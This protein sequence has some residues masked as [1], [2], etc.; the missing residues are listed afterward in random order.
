MGTRLVTVRLAPYVQGYWLIGASGVIA[1]DAGPKG[2][3]QR[4]LA[5]LQAAGGSSAQVRLILVTH[6]HL[7]HF[8]GAEALRA[9][10]GAPVAVHALDAEALHRGQNDPAALRPR[11]WVARV[12]QVLPF[13][14]GGAPLAGFK[15]DLVIAEARDFDL[16]AYGIPGRLISTPGHTPGSVSLLLEDG[17]ALIGDLLMGQLWAPQSPTWPFFAWDPQALL[18]SVRTLLDAGAQSFYPAHGGPLDARAVWRW[19][20]KARL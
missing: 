16:S 7:D 18:T 2:A 1:V 6:G 4:M 14:L 15:P 17:R 9:I 20:Q 3:A 19:W 13:S 10:T 12:V 8:G 11:G 5:G